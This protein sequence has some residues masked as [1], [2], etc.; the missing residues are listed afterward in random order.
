MSSG[1][2]GVLPPS[3]SATLAFAIV[4]PGFGACYGAAIGLRD[5]GRIHYSI[6]YPSPFI[7]LESASTVPTGMWTHIAA[8]YDGAAVKIYINGQL[9][10]M[11]HVGAI[12]PGQ[13]TQPLRIGHTNEPAQT[14][15]KGLIDEVGIYTRALSAVE[16]DTI[17][18]AGRAGKCNPVGGTLT[19]VRPKGVIVRCENLTTGQEVTIQNSTRSWNCEAAGLLVRTGDRLQQIVIEQ[20]D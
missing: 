1:R 3:L 12:V 2:C 13:T 15:F 17:F 8:A 6:S 10:A 14:F 5:D 18:T 7:Y 4:P 20:A 11:L 16:I 9:D 19:G